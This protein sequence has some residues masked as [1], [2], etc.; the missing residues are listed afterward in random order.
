MTTKKHKNTKTSKRT[1]KKGLPNPASH[2][3]KIQAIQIALEA[4][5]K[6]QQEAEQSLKPKQASQPKIS[7][8]GHTLAIYEKA[9]TV[10]IEVILGHSVKG[11][12]KLL[13]DTLARYL[14]AEGFLQPD[15]KYK[16]IFPH[17][18]REY[19]P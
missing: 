5:L 3:D 6:K 4:M 15:A 17:I 11:E 10:E 12:L 1:L 8:D 14:K 2:E 13:A 9:E 16:V 18:R 7:V 19:T